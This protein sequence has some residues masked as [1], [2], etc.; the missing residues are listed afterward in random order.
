M[1]GEYYRWLARDV[2]PEEKRE[3]TPAQKRRN[4]WDYH[5]WHVVIGILCVIL[6]AGV[7]S[8]AVTVSRSQ[9]D[10]IITYVGT[11]TLP[12]DTRSAVELALADFGE[13][14]NGNGEV[15]VEILEYQFS[16]ETAGGSAAMMLMV[17][18]ETA[19]SM[20]YLLEDPAL[21]AANYPILAGV[22]GSAPDS[23]APLWY[24]WGDCPVLAGLE[25]GSF[26]IS[27]EDGVAQVDSR[28][29]MEN[30]CIARRGVWDEDGEETAGGALRL[31]N[32]L[33]E[34]AE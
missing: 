24:R 17:H 3:L 7:I 1:A 25:L 18:V 6:A 26:E 9:P 19:E 11:T 16:G 13:D 34:G 2:K 15:R 31:W 8:D 14:L 27:V 10:Y 4:W 30:L 23:G 32:A 5:K 20:I 29:V 12:E 22:D 21:F 33:T 28:E